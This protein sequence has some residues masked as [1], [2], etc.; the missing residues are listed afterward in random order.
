[1][2]HEGWKLVAHPREPWH[3]YKIDDDE[4]ELND[5]SKQ[6]PDIVQ[7]MDKMWQEWAKQNH[8]LPKPS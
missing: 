3:L 4:T 1:M 7:M 6:H 8:V 2:R 5:L